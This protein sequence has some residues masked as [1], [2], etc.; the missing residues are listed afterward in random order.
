MWTCEGRPDEHADANESLLGWTRLLSAAPS[1]SVVVCQ[2][3][4][5]TIA[6]MGELSAEALLRRKIL[7]YLVD[8]GC[9]DTDQITR[10]GFAVFC[11]YRTPADIVGRWMVASLG[12]PIEIGGVDIHTGDFLLAD[13]DGAIVI[14]VGSVNEVV[15][16]AEI[17]VT[18]ES[19]LRKA[20]KAGMDP[21][22]AYDR[23]GVF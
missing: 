22:E 14:P 11:R 12:R 19:E 16:A 17:L 6:H 3:N 23:F 2:P 10:R 13:L 21:S 1:G 9:R 20:I 7:G 8:G 5:S 18:T 4:D 15:N